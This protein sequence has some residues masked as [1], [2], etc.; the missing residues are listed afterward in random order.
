MKTLRIEFRTP[1]GANEPKPN[2][3]K[4]CPPGEVAWRAMKM[5][6]AVDTDSL[7]CGLLCQHCN[8]WVNVTQF[9]AEPEAMPAI[10]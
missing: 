1:L 5:T 6:K 4:F 8:R 10:Q 9:A 2:C 7:H 3:L